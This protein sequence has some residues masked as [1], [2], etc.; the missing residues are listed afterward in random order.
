MRQLRDMLIKCCNARAGQQLQ[1]AIFIGP[2]G[3]IEQVMEESAGDIEG[4]LSNGILRV[5]VPVGILRGQ[6]NVLSWR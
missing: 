4:H 3:V 2:I 6:V 5:F 1:A